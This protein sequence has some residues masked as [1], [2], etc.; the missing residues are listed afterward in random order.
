MKKLLLSISIFSIAGLGFS[1]S[2]CSDLFFSEYLEGTGSN[3]AIEIYNPTPNAINLS[4][5]SIVKYQNGTAV[6][7]DTLVMSGMLAPGATYNVVDPDSTVNATLVA[8]QDTLHTVTFFNGNDALFLFNQTT[9]IDVI[10]ETTGN[11]PGSHWAVDSGFTNEY[12]LVRKASIQMGTTNWTVG[13]TQWDVYAQN[14]F[15][16]FGSHTMT[17]CT[18]GIE[19][20]TGWELNIYPN[21]TSGSLNISSEV[22][23]YALQVFDLTGKMVINKIHLS[24]NAHVDLSDLHNGIYL[25]K[26]NNGIHQITKKVILRK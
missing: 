15:T 19:N 16:H 23:D 11:P 2:P 3:K 22:N 6:A 10:G 24:Q 20:E 25:I 4:N 17:A 26:V 7:N 1:Q 8:L 18:G 12:T 5:Y 21:P 13:A 14:D 9:Q